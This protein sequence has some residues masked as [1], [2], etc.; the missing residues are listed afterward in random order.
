MVDGRGRR[1]QVII[2]FHYFAS[3]FVWP[4]LI[5]KAD[6]AVSGCMLHGTL[7]LDPMVHW[8]VYS[9]TFFN[10]SSK[11]SGS[12]QNGECDVSNSTASWS[13]PSSFQRAIYGSHI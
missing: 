7:K 3:F 9:K 6:R 1:I 13:I 2:K 11:V 5:Y 8:Q 10:T 12:D 4:L